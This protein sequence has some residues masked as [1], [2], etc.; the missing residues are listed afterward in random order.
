MMTMTRILLIGLLLAAPALGKNDNI[1]EQLKRQDKR[2]EMQASMKTSINFFTAAMKKLGSQKRRLNLPPPA[3]ATGAARRLEAHEAAKTT[4]EAAAPAPAT[5]TAELKTL[6]ET[7]EAADGFEILVA[8]VKAAGLD[9]AVSEEGPFTIMAP[10]DE[11]FTKAF[12]YLE[13]T[14]EEALASPFLGAILLYHAVPAKVMAA[15]VMAALEKDGS[16]TVTTV[17]SETFEVKPG[18]AGAT[19]HGSPLLAEQ[20]WPAANVIATDIMASNGV[21]HVIDEMLVPQSVAEAIVGS[22][23]GEEAWIMPCLKLCPDLA[24]LESLE[25][26][27]DAAADFEAGKKTV[28][29]ADKLAAMSCVTDKCA[30]DPELQKDKTFEGVLQGLGPLVCGCACDDY[31]KIAFDLMPKVAQG[32]EKAE[33]AVCPLLDGAEKCSSDTEK[34]KCASVMEGDAGVMASLMKVGCLFEKKGC[35]DEGEGSFAKCAEGE[36]GAKTG[37]CNDDPSKEGC[38]DALGEFQGCMTGG[39]ECF[40]LS[41]GAMIMM[42]K[43]EEAQETM[44]TVDAWAA[45]CPDKVI[46][47]SEFEKIMEEPVV[48]PPTTTEAPGEGS[49]DESILRAGGGL[50]AMIALLLLATAVQLNF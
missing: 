2:K 42:S 44:K 29:A 5:E 30:A 11:A 24:V 37:A 7:A 49:A 21:I 9:G 15:D 32:D 33:K 18:D 22:A 19:I 40:E 10:T 38:C 8:A 39:K 20:G 34:D 43:E 17:G 12:E 46:K 4:T 13:I 31:G 16:M 45:A 48:D 41:M 6:L 3:T 27:M 14:A 47:S 36:I 25:K 1:F 28:C 26:D 23:G 50:S 35:V